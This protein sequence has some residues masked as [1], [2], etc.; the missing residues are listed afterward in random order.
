MLLSHISAFLV[1]GLLSTVQAAPT[2]GQSQSTPATTVTGAS[3]HSKSSDRKIVVQTD[4]W[5]T[6]WRGPHI[7]SRVYGPFVTRVTFWG[8]E[9][10]TQG[11]SLTAAE[12]GVPD[13]VVRNIQDVLSKKYKLLYD[14]PPEFP[15]EWPWPQY[16]DSNPYRYDIVDKPIS[17]LPSSEPGLVLHIWGYTRNGEPVPAFYMRYSMPAFPNPNLLHASETHL[18]TN[19]ASVHKAENRD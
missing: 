13:T 8:D 5:I 6:E 11:R 14:A 10:H 15:T 17:S 7:L 1:L 2:P 19:S 4:K 12:A 3:D 9:A 18:R 16:T